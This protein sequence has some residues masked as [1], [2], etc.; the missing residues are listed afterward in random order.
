MTEPDVTL[1]DFALAVACIYFGVVVSKVS[2]KT[3]VLKKLWTM[4]FYSVAAGAITG[5]L[6]HGYFLDQASIG[7]RV[8]WPMTLIAIGVTSSTTWVLAG[9]FIFGERQ[10]KLFKFYAIIS[11]LVHVAIVLFVS[12]KF[13]VVILNYLPPITVLF[14]MSGIRFLRTKFK[15]YFWIALGLG[16][17]FVASYLQHAEIAID[18][19]Y[20]N[21]NSTF[22]LVQGLG[23]FVVFRGAKATNL[24]ASTP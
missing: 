11:F 17:C 20:F 13:I 19:R 22:H 9:Y 6:V 23:L 8:L 7:Y 21:H 16:I 3:A 1:T 5:G 2:F 12:Q 24:I 14:V 4:F 15:P 18:P 10:L